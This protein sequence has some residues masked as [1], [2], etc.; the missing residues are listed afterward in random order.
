MVKPL[1][2]SLILPALV[3]STL[4]GCGTAPMFMDLGN[5]QILRGTAQGMAGTTIYFTASD[6][7]DSLECKGSFPFKVVSSVSEGEVLCD[8]HW[9][10]RFRV[11]GSGPTWRGEGQFENG[12]SFKLF[13]N[14]LNDPDKS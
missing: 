10:G 1:K 14:Y 7:S 3:V 11:S 4:T 5:N 2:H 6:V 8:N 12:Q 13:I 9:K